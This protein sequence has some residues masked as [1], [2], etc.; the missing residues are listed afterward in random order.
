ML[1]LKNPAPSGWAVK[2]LQ[3]MTAAADGEPVPIKTSLIVVPANLLGQVCVQRSGGLAGWQGHGARARCDAAAH[4]QVPV[5]CR[6]WLSLLPRPRTLQR[7]LQWAEEIERHVLPGRMTVGRYI[8][9]GSAEAAVAADPRDSGDGTR[10][11]RSRRVKAADG[12]VGLPGGA[13]R[14]LER[15]PLS[16]LPI[17]NA[18][19]RLAPAP[20]PPLHLAHPHSQMDPSR[21]AVIRP[22]QCQAADGALVPM[23]EADV[24]L[25]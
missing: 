1:V 7:L 11:R 21:G 24:V 12:T 16:Q 15:V 8:P 14:R 13:A 3:G 10:T 5:S 9:P 18:P 20:M 2:S 22:I 17:Y 23:H 25:M 6:Q 4:V 19:P